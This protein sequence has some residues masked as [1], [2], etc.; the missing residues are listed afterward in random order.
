MYVFVPSGVCSK[1]IHFDVEDGKLYNLKFV[2]GCPGSLEAITRLLDGQEIG[3]I[4][5]TIKGITCGKKSTSCPDQLTRVL[6]DILDG[7]GQGY[8]KTDVGAAPFGSF[9]PFA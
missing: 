8:E 4:I 3:S 2:G 5:G 1:E 7:N 9:N 6:Q